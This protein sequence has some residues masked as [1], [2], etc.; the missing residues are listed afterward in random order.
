MGL[1]W[2]GI[3]GIL[4]WVGVWGR[5]R[6]WGT[7]GTMAAAVCASTRGCCA[8]APV[9]SAVRQEC[10]QGSLAWE[11]ATFLC[12]RVLRAQDHCLTPPRPDHFKTLV[13]TL[14]H[15]H[16][17]TYAHTYKHLHVLHYTLSSLPLTS[18]S[19]SATKRLWWRDE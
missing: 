17:Q 12:S 14:A 15:T 19:H 9:R 6:L 16:S 10:W 7:G 2:P 18:H 13:H 1:S 11:D 3:P 8:V 5:G 4:S